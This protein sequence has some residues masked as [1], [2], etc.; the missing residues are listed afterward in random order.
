[1][2]D[3]KWGIWWM[4]LF[5]WNAADFGSD[6]IRGRYWWALAGGVAAVWCAVMAYRDLTKAQQATVTFTVGRPPLDSREYDAAM[7]R[8]SEVLA[9]DA[10][11][12]RRLR[13]L[14]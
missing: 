6:I 13:D 7:Q 8:A 4:V 9:R 2:S 10:A 11:R 5:A 12:M 3:H 1:M 14:P